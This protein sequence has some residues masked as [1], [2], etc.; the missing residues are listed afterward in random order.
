MFASQIV[1]VSVACTGESKVILCTL[2]A[3]QDFATQ[4]AI[5]ISR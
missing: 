3:S 5:K 2:P 1:N 4:E